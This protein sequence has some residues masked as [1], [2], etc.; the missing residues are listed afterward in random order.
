[1]LVLPGGRDT[2]HKDCVWRGYIHREGGY[3]SI[4]KAMR[5]DAKAPSLEKDGLIWRASL[6]RW[7][8]AWR[9]PV[10]THPPA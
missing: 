3:R 1:M 9:N 10:P 5:W 7:S 4:G 6:L 2:L 8:R